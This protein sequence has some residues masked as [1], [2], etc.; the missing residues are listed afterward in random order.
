M[1]NLR[2]EFILSD[3]RI[4]L[5]NASQGPSPKVVIETIKKSIDLIESSGESGREQV[6]QVRNKIADF[7]N[8]SADT[9]ALT[10]NTTEGI[11]MIA[12]S[13]Q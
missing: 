13:L 11:N 7:L 2:N 10:G 8:V 9:I 6:E 3:H 5:N 4:F 1:E 12:H